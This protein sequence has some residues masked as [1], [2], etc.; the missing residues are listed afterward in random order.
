MIHI[1]SIYNKLIITP[2]KPPTPDQIFDVVKIPLRAERYDPI[3]TNYEKIS[4]STIFSATFIHY[5]LPPRT[6]I[7]RLRIFFRLETI[8]IHNEYDLYSRTCSDGSPVIEK[9]DFTVSYKPVAGIR[10]IRIIIAI[11]FS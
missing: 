2:T 5:L 9:V 3:S 11:E 7:L 10:Y 4:R 1:Q 6:K 8:Y